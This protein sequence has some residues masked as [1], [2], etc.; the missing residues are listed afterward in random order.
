MR[1]HDL[2]VL[3]AVVQR[4]QHDEAVGKG[5]FRAQIHLG[6]PTTH[7]W[8]MVII[9]VG[10]MKRGCDTTPQLLMRLHC[11]ILTQSL[12]SILHQSPLSMGQVFFLSCGIQQTLERRPLSLD[13]EAMATVRLECHSVDVANPTKPRCVYHTYKVMV[14]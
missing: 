2:G 7:H 14:W 11:S 13:H 6:Q 9:D 5:P 8:P 10:E 1:G 12:A 3:N 4:L